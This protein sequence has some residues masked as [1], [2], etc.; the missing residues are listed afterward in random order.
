MFVEG[1]YVK[2]SGIASV[3]V[4]GY[5]LVSDIPVFFNDTLVFG[6]DLIIDNLEVELVALQSEAVHNEVLG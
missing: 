1:V 3:H 6:T 5:N 4:W 2:F